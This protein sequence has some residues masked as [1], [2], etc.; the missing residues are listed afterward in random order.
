VRVAEDFSELA[1]LAPGNHVCWIVDEPSTYGAG[2]SAVLA[3]AQRWNEKPVV[4]GPAGT[5]RDRLGHLAVLAADPWEALLGDGPPDPATMVAMFE[6]Q[7]ALARSEGYHGV[8]LVADMDWLLPA[9][10][11]TADVVGFE[12][13]L[14]R[15]AKRL[16]ATIV[17]AYRTCSF[18]VGALTGALCVHPIAVGADDEP[19]FR[20]V[21]GDA[22]TWQLAGE[23]DLASSSRF[24]SAITTAIDNGPLVVEA[25]GLQFIGLAGLRELARAGRTAGRKVTLVGAPPVAKRCWDVAGLADAVPEISFLN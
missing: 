15:H 23:I 25:S 24:R 14:D 19:A 16:G 3:D 2:A 10:P 5:D 1:D 7:T 4:F 9:C 18:D 8:R 21:A 6:E 22:E 17:C 12:L 20:L 11:S 13:L